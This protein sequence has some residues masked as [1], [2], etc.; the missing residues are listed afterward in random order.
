MR[1]TLGGGLAAIAMAASCATAEALAPASGSLGSSSSVA[2]QGTGGTSG[3]NA[4]SAGAAN[5]GTSNVGTGGNA[6]GSGGAEMAGTGGS[7]A[8]GAG[9]TT[10]GAG[11]GGT[12]TTAGNGGAAG[13]GGAAGRGIA[14]NGGT[15]GA[16]GGVG[17]AGQG[18]ASGAGGAAGTGDGGVPAICRDRPIPVKSSWLATSSINTQTAPLA[19]DADVTTR[20][21]TG[22]A[23]AG[24]EWLEVNFGATAAIDQVTLDTSSSNDYP[25]HW[26]VRVTATSLNL[27]A[28]VVIEG[29]GSARNIV[30]TFPVPVSG[31][32]LL[33]SQTGVNPNNWW[34][35]H[36]LNVG[37]N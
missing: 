33:I 27:L 8:G 11:T 34:S 13:S 3:E 7:A 15:A 17:G 25:A 36:D 9:G 21:T 16:G 5:G 24:D 35:V 12:S 26:Q 28:P 2:T 19:I 23:Q 6:S 22:R 32:Y 20:F 37:C 4:G 10:G 30:I 29:D 18:G 14:G 1:L 31:Q